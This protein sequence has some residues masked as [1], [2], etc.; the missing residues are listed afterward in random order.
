MPRKSRE[1][2]IANDIR[3]KVI[4]PFLK[5]LKKEGLNDFKVLRGNGRFP[6]R[7]YQ[8]FVDALVRQLLQRILAK[9][10]DTIFPG[11]SEQLEQ[12][13]DIALYL[14]H[15]YDKEDLSDDWKQFRIKTRGYVNDWWKLFGE[16][17]IETYNKMDDPTLYSV[18]N[19]DNY[20]DAIF[21]EQLF[22]Q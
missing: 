12:Y 1:S 6:T 13:K 14:F 7:S 17:C 2:N 10:C 19:I 22:N 9:N 15:N 3:K 16:Q 8:R 20:L 11:N 18:L 4:N 5:R 21:E